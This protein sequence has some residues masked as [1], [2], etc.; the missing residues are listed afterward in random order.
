M[1]PGRI[2]TLNRQLAEAQQVTL[3]KRGKLRTLVNRALFDLNCRIGRTT[4]IAGMS[5]IIVSVFLAM[6]GT[7]GSIPPASKV[8]IHT[9]EFVATAVFAIEY[10]LRLWSAHRPWRYALSFY[11]IVDLMTWLP[12]LLIG[13]VTLA[14]RMLRILR[15]LK[16]LRYLRAL[17]LFL[18]SMRDVLD[19]V[20]ILVIAIVIIAL[21]AGNLIFFLEPETFQNAFIG[22]W[23]ALVTMT[24][25]GYGDMVPQT[26]GGKIEAAALMLMG[27]SLFALLTGTISVKVAQMLKR[28]QN[29]MLCSRGINGEYRYCP[30][31]G[32][33]Q[34]VEIEDE[35][36]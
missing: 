17:E 27:I 1:T 18:R 29:C 5:I 12:L 21:I 26:V 4:N 14:I 13:D 32:V 35:K 9:I 16:L 6:I 22:T 7:L 10:F 31:C 11:G 36:E 28:N 8:V 24:T 25:V 23:W 20:L 15:L 33:E 3:P 34:S 30:H 2:L 19:I